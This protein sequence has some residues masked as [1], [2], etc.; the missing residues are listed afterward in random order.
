MITTVDGVTK[1]EGDG[2]WYMAFSYQDGKNGR[3]YPYA[4]ILS[5][6]DIHLGH[7]DFYDDVSILEEQCNLMNQSDK[8]I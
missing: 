6:E 2:V 4:T 8:N 5:E 1:K 7:I 3:Y